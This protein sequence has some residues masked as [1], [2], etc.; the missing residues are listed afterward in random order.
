VYIYYSL[1]V[2]QLYLLLFSSLSSMLLI[3]FCVL[4]V[5]I[6]LTLLLLLEVRIRIR[7]PFW[8]LSPTVWWEISLKLFWL[9]SN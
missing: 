9:L 5:V 4:Y 6:R 3:K 2:F 1:S 8:S 7:L